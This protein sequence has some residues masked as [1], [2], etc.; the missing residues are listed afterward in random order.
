MWVRLTSIQYVSHA[1]RQRP[2]HPGEWVNVGKQQALS[3]LAAGLAERPDMPNLKVLTGCGVVVPQTGLAKAEITL[4]GVEVVAGDPHLPFSKT[5]WW[6]P[7]TKLRT[8]LI[9]TGFHLLDT[10]EVAAPL[11]S[12]EILARDIGGDYDRQRTETVVR[13]LRVPF[14]IPG[15]LFLR[16][17]R[18][19]RDLLRIWQEEQRRGGD[20]RLALLRAIYRVKPLLCS[21]P[22]TWLSG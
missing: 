19:T 10:W 13:D 6:N 9:A 5:L 2:H 11:A 12:Y 7:E 1:G 16:R 18:A 8:D 20:D 17:C 22:T 4:P 21:L 3:W 14:Y 15:A